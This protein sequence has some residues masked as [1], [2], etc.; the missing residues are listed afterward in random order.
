MR[1]GMGVPL[2]RTLERGKSVPFVDSVAFEVVLCLR[3]VSLVGSGACR[4]GCHLT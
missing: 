4:V 1:E 2:S 3:Y